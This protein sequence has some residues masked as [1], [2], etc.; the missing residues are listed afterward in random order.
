MSEPWKDWIPGVLAREQV[1]MLRDAGHIRGV[2]DDKAIGLSAVDLC[3][4]GE[5]WKMR[6][7]SVKP[8]GP[9]SY[10]KVILQNDA[11]VERL[12]PSD[13]V[14]QLERKTTYLFR[15]KENLHGLNSSQ[16]YGQATARSSI[17]RLDVLARLIVEGMNS[18]EEFDPKNLPDLPARV[19]VNDP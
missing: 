10:R 19:W 7:G 1:L 6:S 12:E 11:F 16:I 4:S 17:G 9:D 8:F 14:F 2:N 5:G 3:L 15:L 18:Y 13:G